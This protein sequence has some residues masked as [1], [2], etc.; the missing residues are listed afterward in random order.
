MA[1]D[2]TSL[3][4]IICQIREREKTMIEKGGGNAE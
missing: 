3:Y 2:L 1:N 4:G